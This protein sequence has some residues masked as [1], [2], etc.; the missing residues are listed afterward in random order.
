MDKCGGVGGLP[1]VNEETSQSPVSAQP[2]CFPELFEPF[3]G[4]NVDDRGRNRVTSFHFYTQEDILMHPDII[5]CAAGY[6]Q[7]LHFLHFQALF[8]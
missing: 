2:V 4:T 6:S 8:N 3:L 1:I 7:K 5:W